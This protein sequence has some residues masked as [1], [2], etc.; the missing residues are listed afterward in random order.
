MIL[1]C[2]DAAFDEAL[3]LARSVILGVFRKIAVLARIRDRLDHGRAFD[4]L[5]GLQFIL[6]PG[7]TR[8]RDR[9]LFHVSHPNQEIRTVGPVLLG[10][11]LVSPKVTEGTRYSP[12][13]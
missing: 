2:G 10:P 4:R 5:Q 6:Q 12:I 1:E 11:P 7:S 9:N 8:G 13:K 3:M